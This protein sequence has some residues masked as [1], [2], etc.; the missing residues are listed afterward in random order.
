[1]TRPPYKLIN[2]QI[3]PVVMSLCPLI[4]CD[5]YIRHICLLNPNIMRVTLSKIDC[6]RELSCLCGM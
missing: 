2:S 5:S 3:I 6:Y 1:M 4:G